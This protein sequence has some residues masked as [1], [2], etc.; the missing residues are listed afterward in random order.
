MK[1]AAAANSEP[2]P[3][4]HF[5]YV[6][7]TKPFAEGVLKGLQLPIHPFTGGVVPFGGW[8]ASP[9]NIVA[10]A[11]PRSSWSSEVESEIVGR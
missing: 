11:A 5:S 3:D 2:H 1:D 8:R 6:I 9:T 4:R 7:S 10:D